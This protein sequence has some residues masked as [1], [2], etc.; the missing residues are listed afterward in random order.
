MNLY[1][2]VFNCNSLIMDFCSPIF[3]EE[4]NEME[5]LDKFIRLYKEKKSHSH[6]NNITVTEICKVDKIIK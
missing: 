6:P 3:L 2:I 5:A 4:V 1:K